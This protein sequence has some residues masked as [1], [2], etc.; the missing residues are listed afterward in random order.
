MRVE[1]RILLTNRK[2][3]SELIETTTPEIKKNFN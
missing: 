2:K 3:I 1:E